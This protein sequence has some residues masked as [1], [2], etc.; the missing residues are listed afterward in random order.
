MLG[1]RREIRTNGECNG[2]MFLK[3]IQTKVAGAINET[4]GGGE[5]KGEK[6]TW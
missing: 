4:G 1:G 5:D 6:K 2:H 3:G